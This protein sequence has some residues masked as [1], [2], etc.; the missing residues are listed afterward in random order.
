MGQELT[1]YGEENYYQCIWF[2]ETK[3]VLSNGTKLLKKLLLTFWERL[4]KGEQGW[5]TRHK[6]AFTAPRPFCQIS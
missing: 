3:I 1:W 6:C 5:N 2:Q 4:E